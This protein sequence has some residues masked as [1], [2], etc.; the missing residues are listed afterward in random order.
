[1][2]WINQI[3]IRIVFY[4]SSSPSGLVNLS[5]RFNF[6]KRSN[7]LDQPNYNSESFL[8]VIDKYS[9]EKKHWTNINSQKLGTYGIYTLLRIKRSDL[10]LSAQ[11]FKKIGIKPTWRIEKFENF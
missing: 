2:S 4:E 8:V 9:K 7:E 10:N 6:G 5:E 3:I 1:M 11:K